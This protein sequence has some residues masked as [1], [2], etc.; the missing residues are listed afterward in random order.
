MVRKY[1]ENPRS[2]ISAVVSAKNDVQNQIVLKLVKDFDPE[3][4]RTIGIITKPDTLSTGSANESK[5]LVLSEM[6]IVFSVFDTA[7]TYSEIATSKRRE[8]VQRHVIMLKPLSSRRG[9]GREF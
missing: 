7:G 6:K 8:R 5:F 4:V 1:M 3:G 2:V 9:F